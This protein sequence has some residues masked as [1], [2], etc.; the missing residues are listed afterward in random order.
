MKNHQ[1]ILLLAV[2]LSLTVAWGDLDF[3][4]HHHGVFK[5]FGIFGGNGKGGNGDNGG[6][7]NGNGNGGNGDNGGNGNGNGGNGG[8]QDIAELE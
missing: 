8:K 3:N 7:G 4:D 5:K 1:A 2:L 6:N